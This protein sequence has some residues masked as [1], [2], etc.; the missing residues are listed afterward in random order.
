MSAT[1]RL[2]LIGIDAAPLWLMKRLSLGKGIENIRSLVSNH[3]IVEMKSTMPPMTGA[4]W[5]TIYTGLKPSEHGVPDFFE[6]KRDY[7]PELVY[8]DSEK[9]PPFWK[10]LAQSGIKCLVITPATDIKLPG[11][12]GV[13][14]ITGFPL[15]ARTNSAYLKSLMLKYG[16]TG[17][18]EIEKDMKA[19]RLPIRDAV[20]T[21]AESIRKRA[22]IAKRAIGHSR[23][24]F[25]YVCFTETDRLQHFVLNKK[26]M[27]GYML[28][29][30]SAIDSFVGYLLKRSAKEGSAIM[31][32]SDHGAQPIRKKFLINTWLARNGYLSVKESV[33]RQNSEA[34]SNLG[35]A[36]RERLMKTGMRHVYDK[37][38][39]ATKR[40]ISK[41]LGAVSAGSGGVYTRIHL[42]DMDM[43][44]TKAFAAVSNLNVATLWINDARFENGFVSSAEGKRV[45]I[46]LSAQLKGVMNGREAVIKRVESAKKYYGNKCPFLAPDLFVEAK[47]GYSIDIFNYS[48]GAIFMDPEP[49]KSGDHTRM[50][51]FG[52]HPKDLFGPIKSYSIY[53]VSK[54]IMEYYGIGAKDAAS[55]NP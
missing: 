1:R 55:Q 39:H 27:E 36:F 8:Y 3:Q 44:K 45:I 6:L 25:V 52:F 21:F 11:Y 4:A 14:M 34:R 35:Y 19:G 38:P 7:T 13:D 20:K 42:F 54:S 9:H 40:A 16:F 12:G 29:V 31:M 23:Y 18:P 47:K 33:L 2:Y 5:P 17:E 37:L 46:R 43:N 48:N 49:P 30:Y 50:G 28:P 51:I 24:G 22:E 10:A 26:D 32:V 53:N 41:S 15:K